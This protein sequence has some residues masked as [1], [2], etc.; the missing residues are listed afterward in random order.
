MIT[1]RSVVALRRL[2]SVDGRRAE[3]RPLAR[4]AEQVHAVDE[5]AR[6]LAQHGEPVVRGERRR[7]QHRLEP[8]RRRPCGSHS[9]SSSIGRSGRITPVTPAATASAAKRS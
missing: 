2:A 4:D 1:G 5:A 6:P 8:G 9:P 7:Q 3:R